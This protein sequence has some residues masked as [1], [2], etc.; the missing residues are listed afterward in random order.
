MALQEIIMPRLVDI[1]GKTDMTIISGTKSSTAIVDI[2]Y[3]MR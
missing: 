1:H 2:R 3:Y